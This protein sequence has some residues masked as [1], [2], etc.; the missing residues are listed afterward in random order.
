M[1]ESIDPSLLAELLRQ[2]L[3]QGQKPQLEVTSNSMAPLLRRGDTVIL[4]AA[5]PEQ[6]S[7]GDVI[8][9]ASSTAVMTHRFW[10]LQTTASS[11]QLLT[12]GDRPLSFDQPWP[13]EALIGRMAERSRGTRNLS[14]SEGIGRWL[15]CHLCWL[16]GKEFEWWGNRANGATLIR[17]RWLR[18]GLRG[19]IYAWATILTGILGRMA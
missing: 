4:E 7:R 1:A 3:H 5:A 6:L 17:H 14:V 9:L 13:P 12:R 15:N 16:A 2:G 11:L 10:G 8:T 19:A 18:R